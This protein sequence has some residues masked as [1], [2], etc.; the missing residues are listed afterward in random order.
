M[1]TNLQDHKVYSTELGCDVVPYE[2]VQLIINELVE[3]SLGNRMDEIMEMVQKAL[4]DLDSLKSDQFI[5][6]LGNK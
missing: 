5:L 3:S 1:S 4:D 2:T 6:P